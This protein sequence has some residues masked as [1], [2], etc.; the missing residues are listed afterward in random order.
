MV[1]AQ[2]DGNRIKRAH[3]QRY[4]LTVYPEASEA[5]IVRVGASGGSPER[6]PSVLDIGPQLDEGG[7]RR[8]QHLAR[9]RSR[10]RRYCTANRCNVL[11]SPTYSEDHLERAADRACVEL[12]MRNLVRR[13]RYAW[14][15]PFPYVAMPE[16]QPKRSERVG[17][18]VFNGMV[19][20]PR[21]PRGVFE[22]VIEGW[23]YGAGDGYNGV[24]V[25]EWSDKRGGARYASKSLTQY[26]SKGIG[27]LIEPGKQLYRVGQGFQPRRE[28]WGVSAP[29]W[30]SAEALEV[31][32]ESAGHDLEMVC[33]IS[34][35]EGRAVDAAWGMW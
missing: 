24:D 9:A 3:E 1:P 2:G 31:W 11:I 18:P 30:S 33:A 25:T 20:V 5:V 29:A 21:M 14:G 7:K 16:V 13:M 8:P 26:A 10:I 32:A 35:D 23:P 34:D 12:D 17:V 27:E 28:E 4:R 15:Q 22:S 19:L 6:A